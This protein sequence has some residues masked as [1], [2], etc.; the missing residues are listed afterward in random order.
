MNFFKIIKTVEQQ[1]FKL[2][3]HWINKKSWF[4][5]VVILGITAS[6]ACHAGIEEAFDLS[7]DIMESRYRDSSLR[8][9]LYKRYRGDEATLEKDREIL[10]ENTFPNLR[11]KNRQ[12]FLSECIEKTAP[13]NEIFKLLT[14]ILEV[15]NKEPENA[16]LFYKHAAFQV[17]KR[18]QTLEIITNKSKQ[19]NVAQIDLEKDFFYAS[20]A[21][22][23]NDYR[24]IMEVMAPYATDKDLT[25]YNDDNL[26]IN[27][28]SSVSQDTKYVQV[29]YLKEAED[30]IKKNLLNQENK[31]SNEGSHFLENQEIPLQTLLDTNKTQSLTTEIPNLP[32]VKSVSSIKEDELKIVTAVSPQLNEKM[33]RKTTVEKTDEEHKKE[34]PQGPENIEA[35]DQPIMSSSSGNVKFRREQQRSHKKENSSKSK[36]PSSIITVSETKTVNL[37]KER[38]Y[39]SFLALKDGKGILL[40]R[41]LKGIVNKFNLKISSSGKTGSERNVFYNQRRVAIIHEPRSGCKLDS[42]S[43]ELLSY[44]FNKYVLKDFNVI[45]IGRVIN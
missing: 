2:F 45:Y 27:V 14:S 34:S 7:R 1:F 12:K 24:D 17:Q 35:E 31:L 42:L 13:L 32:P 19:H 28:N 22:H 10:F 37:R 11:I 29:V 3:A 39:K 18:S 26:I 33:V 20:I 38:D 25:N 43:L 23:I 4:F 41:T 15:A 40:D 44:G 16:T 30:Q 21:N 36:V 9:A 6:L 5:Y 8:L